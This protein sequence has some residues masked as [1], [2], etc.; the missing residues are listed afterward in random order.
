MWNPSTSPSTFV[1]QCWSMA[2]YDDYFWNIIT[3]NWL[4]LTYKFSQLFH[5]TL[6]T[7]LHYTNVRKDKLY[8][9]RQRMPTQLFYNSDYK[10]CMAKFTLPSCMLMILVYQKL[11]PLLGKNT[12]SMLFTNTRPLCYILSWETHTKKRVKFSKKSHPHLIQPPVPTSKQ[13]HLAIHEPS[14]QAHT[15]RILY[16]LLSII[17]LQQEIPPSPLTC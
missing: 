8:A 7:C 5:S 1:S 17:Y 12:L 14:S 6:I 16:E 10:N 3:L 15:F 13:L 9:L 2:I 4:L 11:S